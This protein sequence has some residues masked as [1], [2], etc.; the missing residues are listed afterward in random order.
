MT[1]AVNRVP[2]MSCATQKERK[3]I[4]Q[5]DLERNV[6]LC[7]HNSFCRNRAEGECGSATLLQT[8]VAGAGKLGHGP[9]LCGH[10]AENY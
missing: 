2:G 1:T 3:E 9:K 8:E 5:A 7:L 4:L 10:A 6:S